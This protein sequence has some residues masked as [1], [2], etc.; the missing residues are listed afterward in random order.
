MNPEMQEPLYWAVETSAAGAKGNPGEIRGK[1]WGGAL[2]SL[3]RYPLVPKR[4]SPYRAERTYP[5]PSRRD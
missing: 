5:T 3:I 1:T 2:S 4:H